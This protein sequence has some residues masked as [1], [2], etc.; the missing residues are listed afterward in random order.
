MKLHRMPSVSAALLLTATPRGVIGRIRNDADGPVRQLL[1][2]VKNELNR[3]GSEVRTQV[4]NHAERL[5][6]LETRQTDI[7]QSSVSR[8][9]GGGA[10][11]TWGQTVSNSSQY[12]SFIANNCKGKA[13][14][15]VANAI[16]SVSTSAGA[17]ITADRD[18]NGVLLPRRRLTIRALCGPGNTGSNAVEYFKE[19]LFTNNA[20]V[21][22]EGAQKPESNIEYALETAAV[23]T[24]AH[25]IPAS[26][27]V[28]EDAPQ[29]STLVDSSLRYGL[30]VIEETQLLYGDGTGQ[31][32]HG[33]IPQATAFEENRIEAGNSRIDIISHAIGQAE[34]ADLPASG[35]ILNTRDWLDMLRLKDANGN[36][37]SNGPWAGGPN[38][39]WGLPVVWTN[40]INRG[41]FLVGA[42]ETATQIYDRMDPEVMVSDED[43]DNFIK[44]MLTIRAEQ[45]LAFAVKRAAA[46]IHG[47]FPAAGG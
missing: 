15:G 44:N 39:L 36:Y 7:E 16:T 18:P 4:E 6:K 33:M 21:V 10:G 13:V 28:M 11:M 34:E 37:L 23:R 2:E 41:D 47:T 35:I 22:A 14:I 3:I 42:F 46:L 38:T 12:Q 5:E 1:G 31:N 29:L 25:W 19:K 27:Q 9:R 8:R 32:L 17:L 45:R 26:R 24:I 20:N 40:S 30:A 43:R